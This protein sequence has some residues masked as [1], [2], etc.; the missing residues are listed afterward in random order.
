MLEPLKI[1]GWSRVSC[2]LCADRGSNSFGRAVTK[3]RKLLRQARHS[4]PDDIVLPTLTQACS[5]KRRGLRYPR[6][7]AW[8]T[9]QRVNQGMRGALAFCSL[10]K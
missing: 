2:P 5:L 6:A 1:F 10:W 3:L 8:K 4:L 7:A 9:H